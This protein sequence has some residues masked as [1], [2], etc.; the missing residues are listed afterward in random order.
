MK[1][2]IRRGVFETN[3]SSVH[4]ITISKNTIDENKMTIND[5]GFIEVEAGEF[6]WGVEHHRDQYTK[7]SYLVMMAVETDGRQCESVEEFL[8]TEGFQHINHEIAAHCN[9]RGIV[10]PGLTWTKHTYQDS[11]GVDRFYVTH[12]GYIDHQSCEDYKN[13]QHFL[14]DKGVTVVEFV[15]NPNLMLEIANDNI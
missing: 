9:C 10:I 4:S 5:D 12:D 6:G 14:D 1:R 7:L 15:F 11:K 2:Q 8:K 13:L 3:S